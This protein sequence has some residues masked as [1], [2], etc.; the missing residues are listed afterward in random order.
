MKPF[1]EYAAKGHFVA[2]ALA[3]GEILEGSRTITLR[4]EH[5][6]QQIM[7]FEQSNIPFKDPPALD[8]ASEAASLSGER[9][10][11][12]ASGQHTGR[13]ARLIELA[14]GFCQESRHKQFRK[15]GQEA[16]NSQQ[17]EILGGCGKGH[18]HARRLD[19]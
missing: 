18:M 4:P 7:L 17:R 15:A 10:H 3:C 11:S 8:F 5:Y 2:R 6:L 12:S 9:S 19:Y 1:Q 13:S 16:P 14:L